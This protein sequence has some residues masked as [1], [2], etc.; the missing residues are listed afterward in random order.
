MEAES[1]SSAA[2]LGPGEH[3]QEHV[4]GKMRRF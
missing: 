2:R 3:E 4:T 1:V